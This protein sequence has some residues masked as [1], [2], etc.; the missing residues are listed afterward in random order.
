MSRKAQKTEDASSSELMLDSKTMDALTVKIMDSVMPVFKQ[1]LQDAVTDLK[2]ELS[3]STKKTCE[4]IVGKQFIKLEDNVKRITLENSMLRNQVVMLENLHNRKALVFHGVMEPTQS[5]SLSQS[6][7]SQGEISRS[8]IMSDTTLIL[9]IARNKLGIDL[10]QGDISVLYRIPSKASGPRPILVHF[11]SKRT[12]D[13]LVWNR[14][15]LREADHEGASSIYINELLTKQTAN[16]FKRVRQMTKN[17]TFYRCWTTDGLIKVLLSDEQ[18]AKPM[19]IY[20]E[21]D[22]K[23]LMPS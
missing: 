6:D 16:L 22:L 8:Q 23:N 15:K 11:I 18:G 21:S 20:S 12:R 3:E 4:E 10:Q 14:K 7:L 17:G 9:G 19:K 13:S 1:M 2:K 5:S